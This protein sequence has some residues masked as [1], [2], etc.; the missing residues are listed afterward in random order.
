MIEGPPDRD[1]DLSSPI[2]AELLS[3][4]GKAVHMLLS[5]PEASSSFLSFLV[6]GS[7]SSSLV[8]T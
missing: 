3:S 2:K 7:V 1:A 5:F 4:E 6:G 8:D